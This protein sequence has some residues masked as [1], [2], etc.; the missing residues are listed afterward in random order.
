MSKKLLISPGSP[1]S[2]KFKIAKRSR[3]SPAS[4]SSQ[5]FEALV[6]RGPHTPK[7]SIL[8]PDPSGLSIS[9]QDAGA[10]AARPAY[11]RE[12]PGSSSSMLPP[13]TPTAIRESFEPHH[14]RRSSITPLGGFAS[15]DVDSSLRSRFDQVELIGTGEFSQVYRVTEPGHSV[16]TTPSSFYGVPSAG[17]SMQTLTMDRVY[18]VKKSRHAYAGSRDRQRK[19]QEVEVLQCLNHSDH[20]IHFV[21]SW[22]EKSHLYIQT[23][24]CEEGSL[25]MFLAQVGRKARLDD[26]RIWKVMLEL[27]L[28]RLS[29]HSLTQMRGGSPMHVHRRQTS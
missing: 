19:L 17:S 26:F 25:E 18:A 12:A 22:E 4:P 8:P 23:E 7:D 10:A 16:A 20:V 29:S 21:D 11:P 9:G 1:N 3:L 28:V 24:F 14:R 15:T 27:S 13:A 6:E 2:R 5:Q